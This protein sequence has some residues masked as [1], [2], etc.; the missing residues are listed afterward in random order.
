MTETLPE[1]IPDETQPDLV[2]PLDDPAAHAG[3]TTV[4]PDT[5]PFLGTWTGY[6]PSHYMVGDSITWHGLDWLRKRGVTW[7]VSAIAG[8]DVSCLP[9]YIAERMLH[10]TPPTMVVIAL[11]TN[12]T[13]GWYEEDYQ[14]AVDLLPATTR[15]TFVTTYRDPEIWH[16][17]LDY[18]RR[19]I[20]QQ[21]YSTFMHNIAAKRKGTGIAEWRNYISIR[22]NLLRDGVHPTEDGKRAWSYI[23]SE[24]VKATRA[25]PV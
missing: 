16:N 1:E 13:S 22:P 7:E 20:I 25:L 6:R 12:A 4:L 17:G 15:V 9:Y 8:R 23:V 10:E 2:N 14:A 18:R 21:H 3:E 11:G 5:S 19:A 24:A